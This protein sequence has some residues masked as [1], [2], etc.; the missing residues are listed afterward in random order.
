MDNTVKQEKH[1]Q[2]GALLVKWRTGLHPHPPLTGISMTMMIMV[3]L[4]TVWFPSE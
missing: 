2:S 4:F 3:G 1:S